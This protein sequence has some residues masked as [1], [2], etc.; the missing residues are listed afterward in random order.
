[1]TADKPL[2]VVKVGGRAAEDEKLIFNLG[3]EFKNLAEE[4]NRL[5]LVHGGGVTISELQRK[6]DVEPEFFDGLRQ[7]PPK[8]MPLV[9]M[10]LAGAVNKRLVRRLRSL[11]VEAWGVCG[12]DA[13]IISAVS[14]SG[15]PSENRTGRVTLVNTSPLEILWRSGYFPVL[16]PPSADKNGY[17]INVNADEAALAMAESLKASHLVFISDVPGVLDQ[18]AVI[19]RLSPKTAKDKIDKGVISGG[20]IPKVQ[21]AVNALQQGVGAVIIGDYVNPGDLRDLLSASPGTCIN[22]QGGENHE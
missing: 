7:T 16:A 2:I 8:E 4:G 14:V 12:A 1:M 15:R 19:H 6:Y 18:G 5:L 10:A 11:G 13:G 9:D 21:S 3:R 17:G 20:M 22:L